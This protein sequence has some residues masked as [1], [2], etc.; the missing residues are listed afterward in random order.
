MLVTLIQNIIDCAKK[1]ECNVENKMMELMAFPVSRSEKIN[2][3]NFFYLLLENTFFFV[4]SSAL[5]AFQA[6]PWRFLF[7]G[8]VRYCL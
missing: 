5:F 2:E 6:S 4:V 3:R 7:I 1:K 8:D